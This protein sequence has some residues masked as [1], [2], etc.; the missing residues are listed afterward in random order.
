MMIQIA[1]FVRVGFEA[2]LIEISSITVWTFNFEAHFSGT[3]R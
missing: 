3:W 2:L 1:D